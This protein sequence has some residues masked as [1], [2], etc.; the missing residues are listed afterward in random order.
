[1]QKDNFFIALEE[2]IDFQREK[3]LKLARRF[4]PYLTFDDIQQPNDF[5]L[6][7]ENP[8]FRFEEG[9]LQ[10]MLSIQ[11]LYYREVVSD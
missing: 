2:S 5:P 3:L 6:L 11:V 1:M 10:G 4:Y 8:L 9:I 7:E